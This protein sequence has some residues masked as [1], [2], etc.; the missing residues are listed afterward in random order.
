M[1]VIFITI[2]LTRITLAPLL[3]AFVQ[4][5][6]G[7]FNPHC[8][9]ISRREMRMQVRAPGRWCGSQKTRIDK[10]RLEIGEF[11]G[12]AASYFPIRD[13][14][15]VRSKWSKL[16]WIRKYSNADRGSFYQL[17]KDGSTA[18]DMRDNTWWS[19]SMVKLIGWSQ[20]YLDSFEGR[21][22]YKIIP[23]YISTGR[24]TIKL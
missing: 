22:Q 16:P 21:S 14:N 5:L 9:R 13:I 1:C 23:F 8:R 2:I 4:R 15:L 12:L 3:A 10:G 20:Q 19:I 18:K 11:F 17:W 6:K 7:L 24:A